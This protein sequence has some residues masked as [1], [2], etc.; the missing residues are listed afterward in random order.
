MSLGLPQ[1]VYTQAQMPTRSLGILSQ[2]TPTV[3]SQ[4]LGKVPD[5]AAVMVQ[6][7]GACAVTL[8]LWSPA[9]NGGWVLPSSAS[10][11]YQKTFAAAGMDYFT[12][13]PGALFALKS[14]TGSIT[15]YTDAAAAGSV[16]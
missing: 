9:G 12:A 1:P 4:A 8:Y 7:D 3:I 5:Y 14:D 10:A 16:S 11:S 15:G 6:V 2:S 13:P